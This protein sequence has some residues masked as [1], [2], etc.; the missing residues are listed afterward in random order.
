MTGPLPA[1]PAPFAPARK[2]FQPRIMPGHKRWFAAGLGA[3]GCLAADSVVVFHEIQFHPSTA[4][5]DVEWIE[6][7]NLMAVDVEM[8]GWRLEG[9]VAFTFPQGTVLPGGG[10]LVVASSPAT[11]ELAAG[12]TQVLGPFTGR[13]ANEGERLDLHNHNGRRMDSV[14]YGIDAPWPVGP[15]GSGA[16]LSKRS[17]YRASADPASWTHSARLGGTPGRANDPA[18]EA[19][20]AS[21]R[22]HEVSGAG[23]APF[24]LELANPSEQPVPL[25]GFHVRRAGS[26]GGT[27]AFPDDTHIAAGGWF[28]L[29]ADT[30][31]WRPAAGDRLF[32]LGPD[33]TA[34][35]D[36]VRITAWGQARDD[37]D[38]WSRPAH[39]TFGAANVFPR[40]PD[41]AINEIQY[42]PRSQPARPATFEDRVALP[43]DARWRYFQTG[44][45]AGPAWRQPAFDDTS[46][47]VG[48]GVF[49]VEDAALPAPKNTPLV[50]GR[51]TYY[52]RTTFVLDGFPSD[53]DWSLRPLIDDG[54]AF[55]L[56]GTEIHRLNLPAGPLTPTTLASTAVGDATL[57]ERLPVP[58]EALRPG[59]N[60]LAVEVHQASAG[61][62]DIVF[63]L[64]LSGQRL[65]SP[66]VPSRESTEAWVELFHHGTEPADLDGWRLTDGIRFT[67]PP[68]TRLD[69]G[70]YL[71]VA[72]DAAALRRQHP[73]I[74]ILGDFEGRLSRRS[75]RVTLVEANGNRVSE[76]LYHDRFPWP[77][78]ADGGGS[79]LERLDPRADGRQPEAWAASDESWQGVWKHYAYTA[80]A[81]ADGGPTRWNELVLGLLAAGEAL[82]DDV[83]V[84]ES[85]GSPSARELVLHGTFDAGTEGW[86][87]LGNHRRS[88]VVP[89]PEDP[90]NPVLHLVAS[91]PTEH[92]H[93]H[94]ET[95]FADNVP[96][97]N[98]RTYR[99]SFRAR[100]ITGSPRLHSRLYFNRLARTTVLDTPDLTGTPGRRNSRWV[101]NLGPSFRH[102]RHHPVVPAANQPVSVHVDATDPD[103]IQ[104]A[105]LWWNRAGTGWQN[106]EMA[107]EGH[108]GFVGNLP[109]YPGASVVQFYVEASDS[110]GAR[111]TA[112]PAGP[113]SRALYQ[114]Q[115][116]QALDPRLSHLRI[117]MTAADSAFQFAT[118]NLMSNESLPATVVSDE[119]EAFYDVHV[120]L[121]S[122]QRGRPSQARVGFT[123]NFP[124]NQLFRGVHPTV[125]LDR[126]GGYSGRGGPQDEIVLRHIINQAGGLPDMYN[127]LVRGIFPRP[128][129][130]RR[131]GVAQLL[132]AK[133]GDDYLDDAFPNGSC[134]DLYKLEL[135][136]FPTT[137]V[138]ND[139]HRPKLPQPDEVI[140]TDFTDR[141]DDPEA[142]R[143]HFL[144][145][146]RRDD[147]DFAPIMRLARAMGLPG[148]ALETETRALMDLDQWAR[149]FALKSLSGDAD[150]Y[151]FGYPHNQVIYFRPDNGL[152]LAFPWDMD[153]AWTRNPSDSLLVGGNL[154]RILALP[155]DLRRFYGHVWELLEGA[156]HPDAVSRWTTHYG[157]L[158]GQNYGGVLTYIRQRS[159]AARSQLPAPVPF[160]LTAPPSPELLTAA[161]SLDLSG[162]AW[163][164]L[165]DLAIRSPASPGDVRWT[166]VTHWRTDLPLLLG[167]NFIEVT[168]F[169]FAGRPTA[170][171]TL[172]VV[173]TAAH[174][175]P[176]ADGDGM[177]DAWEWR[178]GLDADTSDGDQDADRDGMTNLEEYLAGTDPRDPRSRLVLVARHEPAGLRIQF[179]AEPGRAYLLERS[180]FGPLGPWSPASSWPASLQAGEHSFLDPAPPGHTTRFFRLHLQTGTGSPMTVEGTPPPEG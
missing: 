57:G 101:E 140:G 149:A 103:G 82:I 144:L 167:P 100:W 133:Y 139:P 25:A 87:L 41:I 55:Y 60:V 171:H 125:T 26:G 61:S 145:E 47:P 147:D 77:S 96:L 5:G 59:T 102:L 159:N 22:F 88:R 175:A 16:T 71:V 127:D 79:T 156:F 75:D 104:R 168:G 10:H 160:R 42:H 9:G 94:L 162:T 117:I 121:Q 143:W 7:R 114:V 38:R 97:V 2:A 115:D 31:G 131:N 91:G 4:V 111:S 112:P 132:M 17:P 45:L 66:A 6:F 40:P 89:D 170:T 43:F 80:T 174:S 3:V 34:L 37:E 180:D 50:L 178:H 48:R 46:W 177:P 11:L 29:S 123:L 56:N 51:L 98:G 49:F 24:L 138:A 172:T 126:S 84:T 155:A 33:G 95:T 27:Y 67:F 52:F 18:P 78:A 113:D 161:G 81:Q 15:T 74:R 53:F 39:P 72:A 165:K 54:A 12:L 110:R 1:N 137:S 62:S 8:S 20:P 35:L 146:N 85:P 105:L 108:D 119:T 176:D 142:Y 141:G 73:G 19:Q 64:E 152:A 166:S 30:L 151:G 136:Y 86:R 135:I 173:S 129:E 116:G 63:G 122:S 23:D 109:G 158:A 99:V 148:P 90:S 14:R 154:G 68:G 118:T 157:Q 107:R 32:L 106:I 83:R 179:R 69:P 28:T 76:V 124:A 44:A 58:R 70:E 130:G 65:V 150:T 92:M 36:A 153:F 169:D 13:L 163:I 164:D 134:G 128:L 21:P 120:R 93:N